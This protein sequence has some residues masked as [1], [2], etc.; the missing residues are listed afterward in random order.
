VNRL[1]VKAADDWCS[2]SQ[3]TRRAISAADI[4]GASEDGVGGNVV[5]PACADPRSRVAV[6]LCIGGSERATRDGCLL[7]ASR[8]AAF[9]FCGSWSPS[10]VRDQRMR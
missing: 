9:K 7:T 8:A 10:G 2:L 5:E 1:L 6:A 3:P 4:V